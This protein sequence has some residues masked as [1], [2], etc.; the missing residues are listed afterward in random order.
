MIRLSD[1][2]KG[3]KTGAK[4]VLVLTILAMSGCAPMLQSNDP[5]E[6]IYW[7]EP[8]QASDTA[9]PAASIRVSV[10]P[11]LNSDHIWI[12]QRDRRL[13][14]YAG[15]TWPDT[16]PRVLQSVVGRS[17]NADGSPSPDVVFEVLIERFFAVESAGEIPDVEL[18]A[19]IH[20]L[21]G[22][23]GACSFA[24]EAQPATPRMRDIVAAHQQV[25]D[26]L[27][28]TLERLKSSN[29][30]GRSC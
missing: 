19:R 18:R 27:I 14:Y 21:S 23:G 2:K 28:E 25:L 5:P 7:L 29:G 11:G 20:K 10:V 24:A 12:L 1:A 13:N 26:D 3:A 30:E 22:S 16:L 6:R 15:A 9:G 8:D 17:L 4:T